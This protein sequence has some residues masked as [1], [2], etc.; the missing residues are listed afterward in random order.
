[1]N[2]DQPD[3]KISLVFEIGY[4]H[5]SPVYPSS[6]VEGNTDQDTFIMKARS[7]E[8]TG[9]NVAIFEDQNYAHLILMRCF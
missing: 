8:S 4:V 3:H 1:M 7:E 2:F 6:N 5:P 9:R